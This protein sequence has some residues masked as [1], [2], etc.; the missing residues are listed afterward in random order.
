VWQ[1]ANVQLDCESKQSPFF[2]SFFLSP[3]VT[4]TSGDERSRLEARY[5]DT[6]E[7]VSQT[8]TLRRPC[9]PVPATRGVQSISGTQARCVLVAGLAYPA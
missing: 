7:L 8:A 9:A 5:I 2:L 4:C 1:S 6:A 3:T